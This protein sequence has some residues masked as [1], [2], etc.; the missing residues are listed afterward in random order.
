MPGFGQ[1]LLRLAVAAQGEGLVQH[2]SLT[3][4]GQKGFD[5]IGIAPGLHVGDGGDRRNAC[6]S[7]RQGGEVGD[8][9]DLVPWQGQRHPKASFAGVA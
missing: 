4:E 3:E 8:G 7:G 1:P 2:L 6:A 5:P 9:V